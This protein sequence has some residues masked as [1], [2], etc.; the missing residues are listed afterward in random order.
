M[1]DGSTTS[2]VHLGSDDDDVMGI[3]LPGKKPSQ[4]LKKSIGMNSDIVKFISKRKKYSQELSKQLH[5]FHAEVLLMPKESLIKVTKKPGS[6]YIKDWK[7]QC[8][9]LVLRFCARFS[10]ECFQLRES[11]SVKKRLPKLGGML[12]LTTA[13][14]WI[15]AN[16]TKLAVMAEQNERDQVL[17][18]VREFLQNTGDDGKEWW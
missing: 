8:C 2:S 11:S 12:R 10:K 1:N 16:N 17:E 14:Y 13:A 15:E 9:S 5:K 6:S 3:N 7:K 4:Q 18:K